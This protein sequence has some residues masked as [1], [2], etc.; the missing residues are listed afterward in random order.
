ML[1][2]ADGSI[3]SIFYAEG[4]EDNCGTVYGAANITGLQIGD[5]LKLF[6][7]D[8]SECNKKL[9]TNLT[10]FGSYVSPCDPDSRSNEFSQIFTQLQFT[11]YLHSWTDGN[12]KVYVSG[13]PTP[14]TLQQAETCGEA[15]GTEF[16]ARKIT[17]GT[18]LFL[19]QDGCDAKINSNILI[20]GDDICYNLARSDDAY[21]DGKRFEQLVFGSG[22]T[23]EKL[24]DCRY[25]VDS[26]FM[27]SG[28]D[29][30]GANGNSLL[31][32]SRYIE[33]IGA[34]VTET[35]SSPST[36]ESNCGVIVDATKYVANTGGPC[37]P[38]QTPVA[39]ETLMFS[40]LEINT[41]T[42]CRPYIKHIQ[43]IEGLDVCGQTVVDPKPFEKISFGSG[44]RVIDKSNCNFEVQGGIRVSRQGTACGEDATDRYYTHFIMGDGVEYEAQDDCSLLISVGLSGTR[45]GTEWH[46]QTNTCNDS[47]VFVVACEEL[48]KCGGTTY[49]GPYTDRGLPDAIRGVYTG[50]GIG[51]AYCGCD[52]ILFSNLVVDGFDSSCDTK[53]SV[54]NHA[55]FFGDDFEI[56]EGNTGANPAQPIDGSDWSSSTNIA[57]NE[58]TNCSWDGQI[59]TGVRTTS[60]GGYITSVTELKVTIGGTQSC[61][62]NAPKYWLKTIPADWKDC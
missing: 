12:C 3:N 5:G 42:E 59:V 28:Q 6:D 11:G 14:I 26:D 22:L 32:N 18:G 43:L 8:T 16:E 31:V 25:R 51:A 1:A 39:F 62:T 23:I 29:A 30:C 45:F 48:D 54:Q 35:A 2:Q 20:S 60:A 58:K 10:A 34:N 41:S 4:I 55:L 13:K 21:G 33:F 17:L 46:G 37:H 9:R 47:G 49:D 19:E 61:A 53:F 15:A 24:S 50:P 44:L 57:L 52:L 27:I 7:G 40:G 36:P 56:S 38:N